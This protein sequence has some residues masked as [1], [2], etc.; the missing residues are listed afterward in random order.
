MSNSSTEIMFVLLTHEKKIKVSNS[1]L[2]FNAL[3]HFLNSRKIIENIVEF[4]LN[5]K[6]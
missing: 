1:L 4:I 5:P 2:N 3:F 6:N